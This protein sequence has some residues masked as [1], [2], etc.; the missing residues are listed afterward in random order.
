M[1]LL[2]SYDGLKACHPP[3]SSPLPSSISPLVDRLGGSLGLNAS[4]SVDGG[5]PDILDRG[6]GGAIL[7]FDESTR[8]P[9]V[10]R[11]GGGNARSFL[12]GV[13]EALPRPLLGSGGGGGT[14]DRVDDTEAF[15]CA[16]SE[17][18]TGGLFGFGGAALRS[19]SLR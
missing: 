10:R 2:K 13:A 4:T 3:I 1:D 19:V 9:V 7:L 14:S 5:C 18:R 16:L 17:R 6:G 8:E 11:G 15:D 12:T